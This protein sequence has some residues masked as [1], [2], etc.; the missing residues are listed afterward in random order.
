[1]ESVDD[2]CGQIE[3]HMHSFHRLAGDVEDVGGAL[4]FS[5]RSLPSATYN[6]ATSARYVSCSKLVI[7]RTMSVARVLVENLNYATPSFFCLS[8]STLTLRDPIPARDGKMCD[9]NCSALS[10]R[11]LPFGLV[12]VQPFFSYG[13]FVHSH[14]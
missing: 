13:T 3:E 11:T 12:C 8:G 14:V 4:L 6:H 10:S 1:V 5:N 2:M 9:N 7:V